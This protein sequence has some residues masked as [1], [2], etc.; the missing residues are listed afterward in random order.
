MRTG[1]FANGVIGKAVLLSLLFLASAVTTAAGDPTETKLYASDPGF[2][3]RFGVSAAVTGTYGVIGAQANDD[4]GGDSG[5]AYVIDLLTGTELYKLLPS[6]GAGGD[7]FG[8]ALAACGDLAVIGALRND[9]VA[10]DAGSAY[11]FDITDSTELHIL[12]ASDG[13][14]DDWFGKS[15]GISESYAIVG[16]YKA[17]AATYITNSGKAYIYDLATGTEL[18]ALVPSDTGKDDWFG[19]G[20]A[21]SES[22]AL[23]GAPTW[24]AP[25]ASA[26]GAAY[27]FDV[28]TGAQLW[29]LTATDRVAGDRTGNAVAISGDYAVVGSYWNYHVNGSD[30]GAVY[31]FDMTDG[32]QVRKLVA[33]DASPGAWFGTSVAV[34][35]NIAIIGATHDGSSK[36]G[37]AYIFDITTGA[38]LGKMVASDADTTD[39]NNYGISVGIDGSYG[40]VGADKD[41][42]ASYLAGAAYLY[43]PVG[44]STAVADQPAPPASFALLNRPNPFN[45]VTEIRMVLPENAPVSFEV[46][47]VSG[48]LL[49]TLLPAGPRSAGT[50]RAVWDG[51]DDGGREVPSGVY[52]CRAEAGRYRATRKMTLIR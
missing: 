37:K 19:H 6:D 44:I 41:K 26:C 27:V 38:E 14:E 2:G 50:V 18:H 40:L 16:A 51:T 12:H 21:V 48:R 31:I 35:G 15:V 30:A 10:D 3:D 43:E 5:S 32:T 52:F 46:Y 9:Q 49:R 29:T 28:A 42:A 4:L 47:D 25:G 24:D 1:K 34:S 8:C 20:V 23:V 17:D 39:E 22:Y 11:V 7:Y 33:S 36:A 45:P 13:A